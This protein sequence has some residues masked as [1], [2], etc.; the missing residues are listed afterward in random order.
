MF[1]LYRAIFDHYT[2]DCINS[3]VFLVILK[4]K[5]NHRWTHIAHCT[6]GKLLWKTQGLKHELEEY[7]VIINGISYFTLQCLSE[8]LPY[9]LH[10]PHSVEDI[11]HTRCWLQLLIIL[12]FVLVCCQKRCTMHNRRTKSFSNFECFIVFLA[13]EKSPIFR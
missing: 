10:T 13:K 6:H 5:E 7:Y 3:L 9:E 2:E 12:L 11:R 8:W 4:T 1:P